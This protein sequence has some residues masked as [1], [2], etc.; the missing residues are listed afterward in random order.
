MN[1]PLVKDIASTEVAYVNIDTTIEQALQEIIKKEHRNLIVVDGFNYYT[2]GI[3]KILELKNS[4]ID[5]NI[6]LSDIE[7]N[8]IPTVEKEKNILD[9]LDYFSDGME[10]VAVVSNNSFYGLLTHSDVIS[11][12]DP[13]TLMNNYK[14]QDLLKI[15]NKVRWASQDDATDSLLSRMTESAY[16]SI[17]ILQD[18]KPIGILTAKD[19]LRLIKEK[20]DLSLPIKNHMT[21]PVETVYQNI[22][23]K[24]ALEFIHSKHYKRIVAV[25]DDG[26]LSGVV[27][28]KDL[29]SLT[30]PKWTSYIKKY[31]D[32][33]DKVNKK[34][35]DK[36]KEF[37]KMA[38]IDHLTGVYNRHKFSE[39]YLLAYKTM[40]KRTND[41]CL[42]ILDI[43]DF[44]QIND[45][46]GHNV[47]DKVLVAISNLLVDTLREV[48]VICR[49]GGEEFVVLTPGVPIA[50]G[51]VLAEKLRKKIQEL[52]VDDIT[53][54]TASFG[55]ARVKEGLSM[56]DVVDEADKALYV[57][58]KN[59]KNCVKF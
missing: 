1:F 2:V 56:L 59:G 38:S 58:K 44:K 29:I 19:V 53:D 33:L 18:F 57:A 54:I 49:W 21:K 26:V 47:G 8:K 24:D 34:L 41:L 51:C 30:Y 9:V 28:Q 25:D 7:L 45:T 12:I 32:E 48:D 40:I 55:V 36:N 3:V 17:I 46:Y 5:M 27:T 52:K 31:Q 20:V 35:Q 15:G 23:I 50:M 10:F 42:I 14:L 11:N 37:E 13:E 22:S 16:D 6:S 43:D 4:D 39:L